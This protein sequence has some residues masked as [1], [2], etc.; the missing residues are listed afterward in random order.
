MLIVGGV[1]PDPL[2]QT[3]LELVSMF[4][5]VKISKAVFVSQNI[6]L[7]ELSTQHSTV[8]PP[9]FSSWLQIASK[10][11]PEFATFLSSAA[12]LADFGTSY[13]K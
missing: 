3:P 4:K 10:E 5:V 2:S 9:A 8:P 1:F 6:L 11:S 13:G 7:L 12:I